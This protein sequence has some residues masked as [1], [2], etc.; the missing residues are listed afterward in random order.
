M[1]LGASNFD[2]KSIPG[3]HGVF[4]RRATGIPRTDAPEGPSRGAAANDPRINARAAARRARGGAD[5][6][7]RSGTRRCAE[8]MAGW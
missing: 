6:A 8:M 5:R 3:H 2:T 7:F 4:R 1:F